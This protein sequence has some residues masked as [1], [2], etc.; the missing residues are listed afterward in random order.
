MNGTNIAGHQAATS[1]AFA[2]LR[3]ASIVAFI[4]VGGILAANAQALAL[5]LAGKTLVAEGISERQN[6]SAT[7]KSHTYPLQIYFGTQGNRF[8]TMLGTTGNTRVLIPAGKNRGSK[9]RKDGHFQQFVTIEQSAGSIHVQLESRGTTAGYA[10]EKF[11]FDISVASNSCSVGEF[12]YSPDPGQQ[13]TKSVSKEGNCT[14]T[15]GPPEGLA[16]K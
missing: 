10:S 11:I 14:V 7:D 2:R 4:A 15:E 9:L 12:R 5:D 1:G 6:R 8:V 3:S 13:L 16:D